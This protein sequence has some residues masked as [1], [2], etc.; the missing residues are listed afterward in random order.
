[1][2]S[3]SKE[4]R[5]SSR[6]GPDRCGRLRARLFLTSY[7]P[8]CVPF[9]MNR[10]SARPSRASCVSTSGSRSQRTETQGSDDKRGSNAPDV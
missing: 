5:R 9:V 3:G 8:I 10:H 7:L 2:S 6:D 1:M 4:S